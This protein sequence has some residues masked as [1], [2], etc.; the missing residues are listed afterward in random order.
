MSLTAKLPGGAQIQ[1]SRKNVALANYSQLEIVTYNLICVHKTGSNNP[2]HYKYEK[3]ASL[4]SYMKENC[5]KARDRK[6]YTGE[7]IYEYERV[8]LDLQ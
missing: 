4:L 3:E 6:T 7:I 1:W 2:K 5:V 8:I